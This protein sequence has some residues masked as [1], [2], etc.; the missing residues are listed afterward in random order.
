MMGLCTESLVLQI[1]VS[2]MH[3][4]QLPMA[5]VCKDQLESEEAVAAKVEGLSATVKEEGGRR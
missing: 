3:R 4:M 5:L 2:F 1:A